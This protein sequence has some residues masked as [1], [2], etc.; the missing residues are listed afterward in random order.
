M[1]MAE[2]YLAKHRINAVVETTMRD[3]GDF[4][5]PTAMFRRAGYRVEAAI[6]AVPAPL[7]RLGILTRYEDLVA[8]DACGRMV[9]V[10]NHDASYAGVLSCATAI[11]DERLVDEV[12]V[13]RRGNHLLYSNDLTAKRS[14]R[15]P[16][17][18]VAAISAERSRLWDYQRSSRLPD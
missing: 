2:A 3:P 6:M 5:E 17:A 8:A 16:P 13:W 15:N 11:D 12:S 14:W 7:S 1:A 18:A 4:L 9:E 10:S